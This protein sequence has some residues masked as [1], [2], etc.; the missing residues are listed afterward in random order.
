MPYGTAPTYGGETPT[1]TKG[2]VEEYPFEGWSPNISA[3]NGTNLTYTAVFKS[4]IYIE[5]ITDSWDD[6]IASIEDGTYLNKYKLGQYK[7]IDDT[8]DGNEH[9]A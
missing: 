9:I 6:I 1:T 7:T 4:P 2:T 3:V 8:T 5:E